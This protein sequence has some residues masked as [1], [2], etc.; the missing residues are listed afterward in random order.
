MD[1]VKELNEM[2]D[3]GLISDEEYEKMKLEIIG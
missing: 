3:K 1:Q 2:K